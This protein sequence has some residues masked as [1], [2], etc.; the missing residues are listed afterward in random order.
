VTV[1]M[2][3]DGKIPFYRVTIYDEGLSDAGFDL[4]YSTRSFALKPGEEKQVKIKISA[5]ANMDKKTYEGEIIFKTEKLEVKST[6][7]MII[8]TGDEKEKLFEEEGEGDESDIGFTHSSEQ[9]EKKEKIKKR[10][11]F[12]AE[13]DVEV[14][15]KKGGKEGEKTESKDGSK[16]EGKKDEPPE[17]RAPIMR[18]AQQPEME[19]AS[20]EVPPSLRT[21]PPLTTS[22]RAPKQAKLLKPKEKK[23]KTE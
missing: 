14:K 10:N 9:E 8:K 12:G 5:D 23:E 7:E 20:R 19:M 1:A 4:T 13:E 17:H 3:N 6:L 22:A 21:T 18:T 16:K 11:I 15:K 2:V